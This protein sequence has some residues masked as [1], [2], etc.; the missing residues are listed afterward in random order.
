MKTRLGKLLCA[1]AALLWVCAAA[2]QEYPNRPVKLMV[3]YPPGGSPDIV[4]RL[5]APK[6]SETLGQSV[7]VENKPGAGATVATA[8]VARAPADGHTLLLAETAQLVIAPY[9]YKAVAYDTL[10]DLAPVGLVT[11]TPMVLVV[12]SKN[13]Q[14]N[15][16]NDL[17]REAKARPGAL[18]YGSL[19]AGSIHAL[20]TETLKAALGL[21]IT[22]IP[23]K[24][25][26]ATLTAIVAG[27]LTVVFS[28]LSTV[29]SMG[30]KVRI[31]AVSSIERFPYLPDVPAISEV[32][33]GYDFPSQNG[34][35]A[36]A[37]TPAAVLAKLSGAL[38][39][40][41]HSPEVQE[42]FKFLGFVNAFTTPEGYAENIRRELDKYARAVKVS[43][44]RPE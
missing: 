1:L 19:G 32:I 9:V 42:R 26:V 33:K 14:I 15:T 5:L 21:N 2:A 39:A 6:L 44:I 43:N 28:S 36:P 37:G 38:K 24:G 25:G 20:G 35:V 27:E 17:I 34:M 4:A 12:S 11:S 30:D 13:T 8:E 40:A 18:N 3:G 31:I 10:K 23:Y 22:Q 41:A 16:L 29:R 7:V